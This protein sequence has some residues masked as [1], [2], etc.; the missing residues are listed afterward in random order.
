MQIFMPKNCGKNERLTVRLSQQTDHFSKEYIFRNINVYIH[1]Y[2]I[3]GTESFYDDKSFIS[4][5]LSASDATL[6]QI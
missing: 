5:I 3:N 1:H 4:N 2:I 6:I